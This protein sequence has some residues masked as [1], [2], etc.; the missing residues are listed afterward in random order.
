MNVLQMTAIP[1]PALAITAFG[2][3]D[4]SILSD[5]CQPIKTS[6]SSEQEMETDFQFCRTSNS[7]GDRAYSD[8]PLIEDRNISMRKCRRDLPGDFSAFLR[9]RESG[10]PTRKKPAGRKRSGDGGT[11]KPINYKCSFRQPLSKGW[12]PNATVMVILDAD[13]F[14]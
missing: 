8:S 11:L 7:A 13:R 10:S 2:E 14:G 5:R 1:I 4:T 3:M 9:P 12:T 6:C